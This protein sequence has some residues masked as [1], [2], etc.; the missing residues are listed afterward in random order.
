MFSTWWYNGTRLRKDILL[1][2]VTGF[3]WHT[4]DGIIQMLSWEVGGHR[5]NL[6]SMKRLLFTNLTI[7]TMKI[8]MYQCN[9]N[10]M[11]IKIDSVFP[12]N[13]VRHDTCTIRGDLCVGW[14]PWLYGTC[15]ISA[16]YH[17]ICEVE[18]HSWPGVLDTTLCDK[19]CQWV[20]TGRWFSL[21]TL[22]SS[23]NKTDSHNITE[24]LLTV[25][26]NT[27]KRPT[28]CVILWIQRAR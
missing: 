26:L 17:L 11:K 27:I 13:S 5:F 16:Y 4:E 9:M 25:A 22:V 15:A 14:T 24:A 2:G 3:I 21:G 19:V 12:R 23:S 18:P 28:L 8:V 6:H 1:S 20:V 7:N 10:S